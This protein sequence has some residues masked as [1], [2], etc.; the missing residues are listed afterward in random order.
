MAKDDVDQVLLAKSGDRDALGELYAMY[1]LRIYRFCLTFR[2]IGEADAKDLT[3]DTFVR[4]FRALPRLRRAESFEGWLYVIARRRCLAFFRRGARVALFGA[5]PEGQDAQASPSAPADEHL[6]QDQQRAILQEELQ[7]LAESPMK[8][9]GELFYVAGRSSP[10][11]AE[12]MQ[13][14]LSTVTTWLSRFRIK[15]RRRLLLRLLSLRRP[16]RSQGGVP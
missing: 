11:I 16:A 14:P 15:L 5:E 8:Q 12:T 4:A 9:A 2:G 10:Q 13:V 7:N 1:H 6:I 3:Q